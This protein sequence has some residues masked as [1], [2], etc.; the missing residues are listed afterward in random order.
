MNTEDIDKPSKRKSSIFQPWRRFR[1]RLRP[2]ELTDDDLSATTFVPLSSAATASAIEAPRPQD[3]A[4]HI[5]DGAPTK[6][7][8]VPARAGVAEKPEPRRVRPDDERGTDDE[9][10]NEEVQHRLR[11][12]RDCLETYRDELDD[13]L[14]QIRELFENYRGEVERR[15]QEMER[16]GE[17]GG[18]M[19]YKFRQISSRLKIHRRELGSNIISLGDV[20]EDHRFETAFSLS[21]VENAME[22]YRKTPVSKPEAI[23]TTKDA[24]ERTA[25]PDCFEQ[26]IINL[27]CSE[28]ILDRGE[29]DDE[30]EKHTSPPRKDTPLSH[31]NPE[32]EGEN[33]CKDTSNLSQD[34]FDDQSMAIACA[35]PCIMYGCL[36]SI[37]S[38]TTLVVFVFRMP[39]RKLGRR[40]H[41]VRIEAIFEDAPRDPTIPANHGRGPTVVAMA[42][43]CAK[44]YSRTENSPSS[45]TSLVQV[46]NPVLPFLGNICVETKGIYHITYGKNYHVKVM[47]DYI[48]SRESDDKI[49][50][51]WALLENEDTESGMPSLFQTAVRLWNYRFDDGA[52]AFRCI[53]NVEADVI[54]EKEGV[55]GR[56]WRWTGSNRNDPIYFDPRGED[57]PG[58]YEPYRHQMG[59]LHMYNPD[60][61]LMGE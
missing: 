43:Q 52:G 59:K 3:V 49:G 16:L 58:P 11:D 6:P 46:S 32:V 38:P 37:G 10:D 39:V 30:N 19:S 44:K 50:V 40:I 35:T 48:K 36:N 31:I 24:T 8:E 4:N 1:T 34:N 14:V 29:N 22:L 18:I 51:R 25:T 54:E 41:A 21:E 33:N 47:G 2:S 60:D 61:V 28:L 20:L 45:T 23:V 53:I 12:L 9:A 17:S 27:Q 55:K 7:D 26:H 15:A 42:P 13:K 57:H 56:W 5:Q